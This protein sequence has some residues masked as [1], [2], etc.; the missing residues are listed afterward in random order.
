MGSS[1]ARITALTAVAER[2]VHPPQAQE[3]GLFPQCIDLLTQNILNNYYLS[4]AFV[5]LVSKTGS[6]YGSPG[7]MEF[8]P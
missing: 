5:C 8:T 3:G 4:G 1:T 7:E 6:H 2:N